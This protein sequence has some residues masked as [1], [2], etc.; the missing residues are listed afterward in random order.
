MKRTLAFGGAD[1]TK[2]FH[3]KHFCPVGTQNLTRPKTAA[4]PALVGSIDFLV[5]LA[6]AGQKGRI[7]D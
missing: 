5:Q 4:A 7:G 6:G 2:M 3:V 1:L